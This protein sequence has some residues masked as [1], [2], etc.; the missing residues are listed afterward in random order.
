MTVKKK[1]PKSV[2]SYCKECDGNRVLDIVGSH[3]SMPLVDGFAIEDYINRH[4]LGV[5]T[6]CKQTVLVYTWFS[7]YDPREAA[8]EYETLYPQKKDSARELRFKVPRSIKASYQEAVECE[9]NKSW[10][11]CAVMAGR[12]LEAAAK[13]FDSR[14]KSIATGIKKMHDAGVISEELFEWATELR[15]LRNI[16]AHASDT[17]VKKDDARDALNF[18]QAIL[19]TIYHLR[20]MFQKRKARRK[21]E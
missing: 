5:C 1:I 8:T 10:N 20:P 3:D 11:A 19:E 7:S 21:S 14:V 2:A 12:A 4:A 9:R 15:F 6:E 13:D 18:L 17:D 16:G